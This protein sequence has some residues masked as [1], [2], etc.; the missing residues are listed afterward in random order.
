MGAATAAQLPRA[1]LSLRQTPHSLLDAR[2]NAEPHLL[3]H[4]DSLCVQPPDREH[5]GQRLGAPAR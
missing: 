5:K 3:R 2:E 1:T 4:D